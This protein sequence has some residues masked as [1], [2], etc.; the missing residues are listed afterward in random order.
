MPNKLFV[1]LVVLVVLVNTTL[2]LSAIGTLFLAW[3]KIQHETNPITM[4][5]LVNTKYA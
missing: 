4:H 2:V 5:V 3:S 1:V